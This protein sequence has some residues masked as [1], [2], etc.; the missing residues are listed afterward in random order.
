MIAPY[1]AQVRCLR[2][3]LGARARVGTVDK[4]QGQQA[5]V[6]IFSMAASSAEDIPRGLEF[7]FSR[8]RLNVAVSR[9]KC[10]SILVGSEGLLDADCNSKSQLALVNALCRL[11]ERAEESELPG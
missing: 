7:Q 9:A 2:S 10:L 4:F 11:V 5:A 6:A 3:V 1:N 8:N